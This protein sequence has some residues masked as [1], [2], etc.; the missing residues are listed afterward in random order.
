MKRLETLAIIA[1]DMGVIFEFLGFI[2]LVPLLVLV[3][4]GEWEMMV[5]MASVPLT[6]VILGLLISRIPRR[7]FVPQLSVALAAV[8]LVWLVIALVGSLPFVLGLQM[9]WT[10][11]IFEA[12]SGWTGTG[13]TVIDTLDSTPKTILFWRSF[14]QWVGGIGVIAFGIAMLSRSSLIQHQL[15]RSEGR[16]E[17][18]MPNVV[19]T[20]RRMWVI[21]LFLTIVF[22]GMVMISGIPLWDALNLVMVSLATGG[23]SLHDAGISYYNNALLEALLIPVM[24]AG[25]LPFK[26]YFLMYRGKI[27]PFFQDRVVQLIL[28]LTFVGSLIVTLDLHVFNNF[29]L[30]IAVRQGFFCTISGLTCCGLQNSNLHWVAGPLIVISL[31]MMIG[32]A[33]GSTAGGIKAN[34]VILGYEGLVWWF[35]RFFARGRAMVPFRHEGKAIPRQISEV[36]LSKNMLIIMLYVLTIFVATIIGLHLVST[37]FRIHEV[38]FEEVSAMSNVGLGVGYMTPESPQPIKWIFIL[39]MWIGRLEIIPVL[40]LIMGLVRGFEARV[41]R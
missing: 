2:T 30:E 23:F 14:M 38:V 4:F 33:A 27:R 25:A 15:Y 31:L 1:H 32:G 17:E 9:S 3:V 22:T 6:F 41:G 29:P 8:A 11:S 19:S 20:G 39:L 21:Y 10:D 13:F 5:P 28:A 36:E 37:D 18:L 7:E 34:R 35:R 16:S 24:L 40:I 26:L 12:M